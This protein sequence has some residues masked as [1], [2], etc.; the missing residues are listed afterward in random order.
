MP[1]EHPDCVKLYESLGRFI[2]SIAEMEHWLVALLRTLTGGEDNVWIEAIFLD[3][4]FTSKVRQK[5]SLICDARLEDNPTL[6]DRLKGALVRAQ[7]LAEE[8][9]KLVH[10]KWS[11]DST[12]Q[13]ITKIWSFK[14]KKQRNEKG[15]SFW[16]HLHDDSV[17]YTQLEGLVRETK[18]LAEELSNLREETRGFLASSE[19][20]G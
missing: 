10:G 17:T 16:I 2:V 3:D 4:L 15:K 8:R 20:G 19:E 9:N 13:C 12:G 1:A 14:L 18:Q 5:I 6:L 7:D 11:I